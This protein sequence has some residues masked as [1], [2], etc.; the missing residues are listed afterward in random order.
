MGLIIPNLNS[1]YNKFGG[2]YFRDLNGNINKIG[3]MYY[4]DGK[5]NATKIFSGNLPAGTILYQPS[6]PLFLAY[7]LENDNINPDDSVSASEI[8]FD[9]TIQLT[10][11]LNRV[12]NGITINF[13]NKILW[14]DGLGG[15]AGASAQY[16]Y[17]NF[18]KNYPSGRL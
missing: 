14:Y 2:G 5:G 7:G 18:Y 1:G 8:K 11:P 6:S 17:T 12:K 10:Y 13:T 16:D 15:N 3:G 9:Q 4:S